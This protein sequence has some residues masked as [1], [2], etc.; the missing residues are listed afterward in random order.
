MAFNSPFA[1]SRSYGVWPQ[2]R[3]TGCDRGCASR[4][5]GGTLTYIIIMYWPGSGLF[6]TALRRIIAPAK[7]HFEWF[8]TSESSTRRITAIAERQLPRPCTFPGLAPGMHIAI[9]IAIGTIGH[10]HLRMRMHTSQLV[11]YVHIHH[12]PCCWAQLPAL[13]LRTWVPLLNWEDPAG[14]ARR[15]VAPHRK[16]GGS[17]LLV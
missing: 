16:D 14:P 1:A 4:A 5:F 9:A 13:G 15:A 12:D 2:I 11:V 3:V 17:G 6:R 8:C 10:T 7:R